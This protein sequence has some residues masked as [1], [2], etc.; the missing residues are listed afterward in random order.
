MRKKREEH[1]LELNPGYNIEYYR[2]LRDAKIWNSQGQYW[3]GREAERR[4]NSLLRGDIKEY[5]RVTHSEEL[6]FKKYN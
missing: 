5:E 6:Y 2:L 4:A 1:F 3:L